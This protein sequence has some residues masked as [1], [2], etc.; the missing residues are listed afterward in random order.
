MWRK[1]DA[2]WSTEHA[3][4]SGPGNFDVNDIGFDGLA[5]NFKDDIYS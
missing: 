1:R 4:V 5:M 2:A 3:L